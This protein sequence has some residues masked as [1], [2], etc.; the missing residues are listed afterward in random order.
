[1]GASVAAIDLAVAPADWAALGFRVDDD[2]CA[3]GA[4]SLRL[5]RAP[6]WALRD[7]AGDGDVDGIRTERAD[8]P[9]PDAAEHANGAVSVD[10]VVVVTP[11]IARTFAAL[12]ATGMTLR[13]ERTT[14][15]RRYGFFRHGECIVEVVGPLAPGEGDASL[16]GLTITVADIDAAAALL[17][18]RLGAVKDA[19]QPGRRI[20]TVRSDAGIGVPLAL[21]SS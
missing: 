13:R 1:V 18:E 2:A 16:W 17:G 14:G 8:W 10:H 21:M 4:T 9:Q 11:D 5:G 6:G 7:A 12:E 3:V 20:A 15:E 19:V